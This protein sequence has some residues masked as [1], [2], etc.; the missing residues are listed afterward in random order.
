VAL[1]RSQDKA[2]VVKKSYPNLEVVLGG[3]DDSNIIK[4]A[5]ADA[6]IVIRTSS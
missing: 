4:H 5:A 3:L 1:T 2:D 6:D